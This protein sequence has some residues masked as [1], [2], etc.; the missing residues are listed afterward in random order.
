MSKSNESES[1]LG[2]IFIVAVVVVVLAVAGIIIWGLTRSS[3]NNSATNTSTST[4]NT[5]AVNNNCQNYYH[6]STLCVFANHI[7][8]ST[9]AYTS[10]GTATSSSGAQYNFTF[11]NDGKGNREITYTAA[12]KQISAIILDG[13]EYVQSGA[14]TTWL[15]FSGSSLSTATPVPDPTSN[16]NLSFTQAELAKYSFNKEGT[17]ACGNLSCVKYKVNILASP[18]IVQYVYFDTSSYL[19]REWSYSNPTTGVSA[20]I[21]I[22]YPAVTITAPSPVQQ[23]TT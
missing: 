13:A 19:L 18:D 3:N 20:T 9:Y 6:D 22:S 17:A 16:F 14:G 21:N 2:Q 8:L 1:G 23:V 4:N 12:G 10:S 15:E 11:K 5:A 7:G